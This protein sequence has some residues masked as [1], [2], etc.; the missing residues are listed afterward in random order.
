MPCGRPLQWLAKSGAN[1]PSPVARGE[2]RA[3]RQRDL[4]QPQE[5]TYLEEKTDFGR[6]SHPDH[7]V[8]EF[9]VSSVC[10]S[11]LE[12]SKKLFQLRR[13]CSAQGTSPPAEHSPLGWR[14]RNEATARAMM[15]PAVP[16]DSRGGAYAAEYDE[17]GAAQ[18]RRRGTGCSTNPRAPPPAGWQRAQ[19]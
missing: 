8:G 7:C 4:G 6:P 5:E 19:L 16:D 12:L 18:R 3:C 13:K 15:C 10:P 17:T 14:A 2:C 1:H 9:S 11:Y